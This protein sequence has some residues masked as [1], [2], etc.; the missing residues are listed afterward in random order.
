MVETEMYV[1]NTTNLV[2]PYLSINL[3]RGDDS[4]QSDKSNM[5]VKIRTHTNKYQFQKLV[6]L[7]PQTMRLNLHVRLTQGLP[8]DHGQ[9]ICDKL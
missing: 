7:T 5:R 6:C 4:M 3:P 9:N 8:S 1:Q 2:L